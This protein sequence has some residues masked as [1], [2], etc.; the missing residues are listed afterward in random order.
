MKIEL[1]EPFK[2][3]W[4]TGYLRVND[5]DGRKR[6]DL[7]NNSSDRTTI[8]YARYIMSIQVGYVIGKDYEIDHIDTNKTN[9]TIENLQILKIEDHSVKSAQERMGRTYVCLVCS[10][11]NKSYHK[12][13]RQLKLENKNQFCS[14]KCNGLFSKNTSG[15]L[16]KPKDG[17]LIDEIKKLAQEG[18]SGYFIGKRLGIS[19]NTALKYMKEFPREA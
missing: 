18:R 7:V 3:I 5:S 8:S 19:A 6:V 10:Q 12:E 1:E 15:L 2:S 17:K 13:L 14:R 11:C 4:R 9:D 16:S